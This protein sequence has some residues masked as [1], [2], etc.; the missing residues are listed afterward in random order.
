[1][2]TLRTHTNN[3]ISLLR[4]A[5]IDKGNAECFFPDFVEAVMDGYEQSPEYAGVGTA[6][7]EKAAERAAKA[8]KVYPLDADGNPIVPKRGRPKGSRNRP[9]LIVPTSAPE[10]IVDPTP[11]VYESVTSEA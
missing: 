10:P 11:A 2:N 4:R 7:A 6:A 9:K 3:L 8:T 1:M 5:S